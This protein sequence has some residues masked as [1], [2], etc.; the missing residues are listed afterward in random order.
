MFPARFELHR[1][2]SIPEAIALL[3][4]HGEEASL[5]AGGTELLV[6]MKARVV[7]I[8]HLVDLKGIEAL[9]GIAPLAGGG[10]ALG[11]LATH[12]E[13]ARD[14]RV[15]GQF[16]A[17]AAL[18]G[19]VANIRVR[20]AGTIGGNLCFGEPHADPPALLCAL[21]A[22]VVLESAQGRRVLP[23]E[24]FV[25]GEFTTALAPAELL[26]RVEV[27]SMPAASRAA[28]RAFGHLERPAAG[29]AAL[30]VPEGRAFRWRLWAGALSGRPVRLNALEAALEGRPAADALVTLDQASQAAV[31][32]LEASDDLHGSAEYKRHLAAVLASRA[33]RACLGAREIEA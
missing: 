3:E 2:R 31:E 12:H 4:R 17:Y 22:S 19:N 29:V 13:L 8:P 21:G 32:H 20:V 23:V 6:A 1:P 26:V 11:A 14:A 5:Y 7:R 16:P 24:D 15:R 9:R 28:Y 18:S 27:P 33:V 25:L 30:A 10:L